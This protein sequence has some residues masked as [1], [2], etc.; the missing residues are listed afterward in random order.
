MVYIVTILR[1]AWSAAHLKVLA[2]PT[3][4]DS[5][6]D[7]FSSKVFHHSSLRIVQDSK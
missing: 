2:D 4:D 5:C 6:K 3:Y 1:M 7:L